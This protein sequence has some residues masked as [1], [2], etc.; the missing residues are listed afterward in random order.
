[1]IKLVVGCDSLDE[2]AEI[3]KRDRTTYEGE[4]VCI[5]RTRNCPRAAAD[6]LQ[7]G[8]S[9]YRVIKGKIRCRQQIAG[10]ESTQEGGRKR[11]YIY[12]KP[13]II[14]T[15]HMGFRPFQGWRYLKPADAPPDIGPFRAGQK[16]DA[17]PPELAETL[18]D[19]GLL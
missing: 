7:A 3:Q 1:M 5:V 4:T 13:E 10:F 8:G 15:F 14:E 2:F 16:R 6:I 19:A 11:C 12:V 17:L 9:I 18:R